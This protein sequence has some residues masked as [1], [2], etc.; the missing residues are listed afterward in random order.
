MLSGKAANFIIAGAIC[1]ACAYVPVI[2]HRPFGFG[3]ILLNPIFILLLL[4][5][6]AL[7]VY[8]IISYK[9]Y[10]KIAADTLKASNFTVDKDKAVGEARFSGVA[11]RE[12]DFKAS[13][14]KSTAFENRTGFAYLNA[15]FFE[16]H[17]RLLVKPIL[18]RLAITA[19]LFLAAAVV[20]YFKPDFLRTL[21]GSQILPAFVFL[22][23]FVSI[24]ERVCKA[25][26]Y[27]CDISLL[28]YPFYREKSAVLSNFKAR[29][30]R[31]AGLNL[32][33]AAAISAAVIGLELIYKLNW[34]ILDVISF[35]LSILS[36]SLFFSV[37]HL[38]LY[39]VFQ[40]FTTELGMKNPYYGAISGAVYM[41]CFLCSKIKTPPSYFTLIVLAATLVYIV[42]ALL[43]V[44]KYAPK[45][46][47]VK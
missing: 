19:A 4:C 23:Y 41:L 3:K 2:L 33:T 31:I 38:F 5:I 17:K 8:Y 45:T 13:D 32:I 42:V 16:R 28:R 30:I 29:L 26:F 39:Y 18:L 46:F 20:S 40:P 25:M 21:K 24:G 10:Y 47:R 43:S 36:L 1:L 14:L 27:N 34:P 15:V 44:Y 35:T 6:G 12:K 11:M 37:H 9:E 22:M 7:C